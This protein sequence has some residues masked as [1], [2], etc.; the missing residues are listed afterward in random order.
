MDIA[1]LNRQVC[2]LSQGGR[3]PFSIHELHLP[4]QD[5]AITADGAVAVVRSPEGEVFSLSGM[6]G[7]QLTQVWIAVSCVNSRFQFQN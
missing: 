7:D 6:H 5:L 4:L 2:L 3:V 1:D